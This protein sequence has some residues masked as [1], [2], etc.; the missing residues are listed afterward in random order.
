[1]GMTG[2][3]MS[4]GREPLDS[5]WYV[6]VGNDIYG[7]YSGHQ[8]RKYIAEGRISAASQIAPEGARE[9]TTAD[10]DP[11]LGRFVQA[12]AEQPRAQPA[13]VHVQDIAF[14][15]ASQRTGVEAELCNFVIIYP[16]GARATT[17]LEQSIMNLGAACKLSSYVWIVSARESAAGIRNLLT[18]YFGRN[19]SLLVVDATRGKAAWFN[20]GPEQEARIRRVWQRGDR[21]VA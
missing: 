8:M 6:R 21:N 13:G 14:G 15:A 20:F 2:N 9:W 17:K 12:R 1:M 7:P 18:E 3:V 5:L 11:V 16:N 19:D 4:T 10:R